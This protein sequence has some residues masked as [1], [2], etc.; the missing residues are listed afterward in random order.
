MGETE[1]S[2]VESKPAA[3]ADS[4]WRFFFVENK[5]GNGWLIDRPWLEVRVGFEVLEAPCFEWDGGGKLG[6]PYALLSISDSEILGRGRAG[7]AGGPLIGLG[8]VSV[9]VLGESSLLDHGG[10]AQLWIVRCSMMVAHR[11]LAVH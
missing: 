1:S 4:P 9:R 11:V 3:V 5:E 7:D 8:P 2:S 10:I 6:I